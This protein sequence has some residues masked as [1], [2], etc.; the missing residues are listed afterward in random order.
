MVNSVISDVKSTYIKGRQ[1]ID[2]PLM[3]NEII[4]WASKKNKRLFLFKEVF[5][6]AFD[7]L[8]W[9]FLDHTM[10]QMGFSLKWRNWIKGCLN[11][12]YGSVIVNG[13]PTKEF[14]INKGLRQGDPL[15]Q[16]LLS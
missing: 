14:K 10:D 13:S 11:S 6:K 12:A 9:K 16:F 7:S 3:V 5:E 4:N 8:D 15:S 1:I 2:G